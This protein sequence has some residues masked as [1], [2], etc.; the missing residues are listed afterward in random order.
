MKHFT[1]KYTPNKEQ[2]A[3]GE[4]RT[5]YTV[6]YKDADGWHTGAWRVSYGR[7]KV[8]MLAAAYRM[9]GF[10]TRVKKITF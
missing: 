3:G 2:Q 6:D 8:R 9:G 4:K 10:E 5:Y 1:I 7:R